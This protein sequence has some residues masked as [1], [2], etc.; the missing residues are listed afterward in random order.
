MAE[1]WSVDYV[2]G[3][4]STLA[5]DIA[6]QTAIIRKLKALEE[7]ADRYE[8]AREETLSLLNADI[9]RCL[10]LKLREL[11]REWDGKRSAPDGI[12]RWNQHATS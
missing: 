10:Q 4:I 7:A 2:W 1:M 11:K 3:E 8:A 6:E 5:Q 9:D 12:T